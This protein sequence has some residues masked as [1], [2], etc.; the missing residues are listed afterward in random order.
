MRRT[1]FTISISNWEHK[2]E[3]VKGIANELFGIHGNRYGYTITHLASGLKCGEALSQQEARAKCKA[4]EAMPI[5]WKQTDPFVN[6]SQETMQAV[7]KV[8]LLV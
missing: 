4:F 5:D 1:E 7:K 2:T 6:A 8:A 3:Q